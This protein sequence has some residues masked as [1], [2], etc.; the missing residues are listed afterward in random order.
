MRYGLYGVAQP[1]PFIRNN[2]NS[3]RNSP[4]N[5]NGVNNGQSP[6]NFNEDQRYP[7][8]N[9]DNNPYNGRNFYNSNV[10]MLNRSAGLFE[11]DRNLNDFY[12]RN[13]PNPLYNQNERQN[14]FDPNQNRFNLNQRYMERQR[15]QQDRLYQ[16]EMEKLRN[17][18]LDIDQK[19]SLECTANVA[20]QWNFETNVN[21]FSEA[22]AVSFLWQGP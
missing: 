9:Y 22:E 5:D 8:H 1:A 15:F 21:G 11:D 13:N 2:F 6:R 20:A 4:F 18:L 17:F 14:N 12:N 7:N 16:V 10:N 3:S 19:S